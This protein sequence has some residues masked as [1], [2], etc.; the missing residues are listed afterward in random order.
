MTAPP[1]HGGARPNAGRP[2][3]ASAPATVRVHARLDPDEA[4]AFAALRARWGL[5]SDSATIRRLIAE[6]SRP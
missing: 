6:A 4:A 1:K 3:R 5:T 2:S